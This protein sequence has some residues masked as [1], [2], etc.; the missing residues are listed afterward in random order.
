MNTLARKF[1]ALALSGGTVG[2]FL[3][4][5][6]GELLFLCFLRSFISSKFWK[7]G[8]LNFL[9]IFYWLSID[10]WLYQQGP[11]K[12]KSSSFCWYFVWFLWYSQEPKNGLFWIRKTDLCFKIVD[13]SFRIHK[14]LY[15]KTGQKE[16]HFFG[17]W[18]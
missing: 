9:S 2:S 16:V 10:F 7:I 5:L 14:I 15:H 11:R 18:L 12:Q 13:T 4:A 6:D 3:V 1:G 17:S 8:F